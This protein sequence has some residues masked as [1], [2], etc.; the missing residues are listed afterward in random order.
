MPV[1]RI[2]S[3]TFGIA[4]MAEGTRFFEDLGLE[5]REAGAAGARFRTPTNQSILLR[6]ME[7]PD[8]PAAPESGPTL[9]EVTWGVDSA[10]T[11]E[12]IGAELGKDREVKRTSD[13]VLHARDE[14]GFALAFAVADPAPA[15]PERP[16]VNNYETSTRV[17]QRV[18]PRERLKPT[19]IGHVVYRVLPAVRMKASAFYL[20]RLGFK[21][22]DRSLM[23]GDFMRLPGIGDHHQLLLMT[24]GSKE[25]R[26][27]H[28][29]LEVA[30]FDDVLWSGGYMQQH[31]WKGTWGPGRQ[32]LGNHVFWHF[33]NPCGGE[34]ELFTDMDRFDDS[35][36][37]VIWE[38]GGPRPV[39]MIGDGIPE[40][41]RQSLAK[42]GEKPGGP[43]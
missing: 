26:F 2:E 43:A 10:A 40:V 13:G 35:W 29:A 24:I 11:L 17:N 21:L 1:T 22:T 37:P 36:Q 20:E 19:R 15:A 41:L 5:K 39:W 42:A 33:A 31:G 6:P 28:A 7:D 14:A 16:R 27:D 30:G 23:V 32:P 9:R 38:K 25:A 12:A 8:L 4:D 34:I 3:L 18:A